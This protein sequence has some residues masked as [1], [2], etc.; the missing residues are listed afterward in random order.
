MVSTKIMPQ[1]F[2]ALLLLW[3]SKEVLPTDIVRYTIT[4]DAH[5][6]VPAD[7]QVGYLFNAKSNGCTPLPPPPSTGNWFVILNDYNSC[8]LEK[9]LHAREAGYKMIF[10]FGENRT[11]T[12]EIRSTRFPI[13]VTFEDYLT[14]LKMYAVIRQGDTY[15]T[16][17]TEEIHGEQDLRVA[18]LQDITD[19]DLPSDLNNAASSITSGGGIYLKLVINLFCIFVVIVA[20][21]TPI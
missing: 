11:I 2:T 8:S 18:V 13:A 14:D 19:S 17:T 12:E 9:I 6:N 21:Y 1:W 7:K 15:V 16:V 10:T 5:S 3:L 20:S 4:V